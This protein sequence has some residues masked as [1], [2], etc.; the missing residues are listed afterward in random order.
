MVVVPGQLLASNAFLEEDAAV[1]LD[2]K[3]S[4]KVSPGELEDD[5]VRALVRRALCLIPACP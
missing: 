2:R 1:M 3:K 4:V 5:P